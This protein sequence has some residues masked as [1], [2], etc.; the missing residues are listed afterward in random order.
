MY[1]YFVPQ[2]FYRPYDASSENF[3]KNIYNV[4]LYT[5]SNNVFNTTP[6][7]TENENV[8]TNGNT[9]TNSYV[10]R[11]TPMNS[12]ITPT[13]SYAKSIE[14]NNTSRKF[15]HANSTQVKN[16]NSKFKSVNKDFISLRSSDVGNNKDISKNP[17]VQIDD[18]G[19]NPDSGILYIIKGISLNNKLST[20]TNFHYEINV[21]QSHLPIDIGM[22]LDTVL[23]SKY[24]TNTGVYFLL[25]NE[26][27]DISGDDETIIN[28]LQNHNVYT[29]LTLGYTTEQLRSLLNNKFFHF[30]V[31]DYK[32]GTYTLVIMG[33]FLE[34]GIITSAFETNF[35]LTI[36]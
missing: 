12:Y 17:F 30:S 32:A 28:Y 22:S 24:L 5:G 1:N 9:P 25:L 34:E 2:K 20:S 3:R 31:K 8:Y 11:N 35:K 16:I 7:T 23:Y 6:Y 21:D 14:N 4:N 13:N 10:R 19:I 27:E 33:G 15:L 18:S 26:D 29:M 36:V